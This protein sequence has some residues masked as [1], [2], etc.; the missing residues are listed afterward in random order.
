MRYKLVLSLLFTPFF[1]TGQ[2]FIL[3]I[4]SFSIEDCTTRDSLMQIPSKDEIEEWEI[5]CNFFN[6]EW[7]TLL[8]KSNFAHFQ[9]E[10]QLRNYICGLIQSD[11]TDSVEY[12]SRMSEDFILKHN[13]DATAEWNITCS[14][15]PSYSYIH[16]FQISHGG[17]YYGAAHGFGYSR[18]FHFNDITGKE[19]GMEQ[20]F[21]HDELTLITNFTL[22]KL[23]RE[24]N[25]EWDD[26]ISSHFFLTENFL[27]SP[28]GISFFYDA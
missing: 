26:S 13:K 8:N 7:P 25:H 10:R 28:E 12:T 21:E 2:D 16:Q 24:M 1:S 27:L 18:Y 17:Y 23:K 14:I 19:I 5:K 9:M 11:Q 4:D 22:M 6:V 20:L 3:Q 15:F